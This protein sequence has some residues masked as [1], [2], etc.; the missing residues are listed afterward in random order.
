MLANSKGFLWGFVITILISGGITRADYAHP[1]TVQ[2][3]DVLRYRIEDTR[4]VSLNSKYVI[5]A[6]KVTVLSN[7]EHLWQL[8]V[9]LDN[10]SSGIDWSFNNQTWCRFN[11]EPTIVLTG[12]RS[13][14]TNYCLYYR[15]PAHQRST[16]VSFQYQIQFQDQ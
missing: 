14:W 7:S 8:A 10:N 16:G 12:A 9:L 13:F 1:V 5:E 3:E 15:Y 6:V 2:I 4:V 11:A